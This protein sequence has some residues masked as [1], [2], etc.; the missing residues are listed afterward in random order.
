MATI[1]YLVKRVA[2]THTAFVPEPIRINLMHKS[3]GMAM[4]IWVPPTL[5][6]LKGF[7]SY[8]WLRE[9]LIT[10]RLATI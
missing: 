9:P 3:L 8:P 1:A 5:A 6:L 4:S 2:F 7:S 10:L